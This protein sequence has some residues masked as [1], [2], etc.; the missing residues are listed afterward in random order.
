MVSFRRALYMSLGITAW[1]LYQV[2]CEGIEL[3]VFA[4]SRMWQITL[5]GLILFIV[6][7][8]LLLVSTWS[9]YRPHIEGLF[10]KF[11]RILKR[12]R[13]LSIFLLPIP[14]LAFPVLITGFYSERLESLALRLFLLWFLALAST[15]LLR[16]ISSR[17]IWGEA[18][19]ISSLLITLSYRIAL[20]LPDI[21][22][23]PFSLGY[24][25]ANRYY[26]ASLWFAKRIFGQGL[27]LSPWHPSR[28]ML[29]AIPFLIS[30]TPIWVHRLWQVGLWLLLPAITA[31]L[32]S[33][34]LK[35][36]NRAS[37]WITSGW[38]FFFLF[39][40][41]VY[42][43]LLLSVIPVLWWFEGK[44]FRR[45]LIVIILASIWAG[46]SRINWIPV[47]AFL[48]AILYVL[49]EIPE[50]GWDGLWRY[51]WKPA[52]WGIA[53]GAFALGAHYFYAFAS[54]N[55]LSMVQSS[56]T[57]D[58]L[59]YRLLP[60]ATYP[61]GIVRGVLLASAPIFF[62]IILHLIFRQGPR[63]A[64]RWLGYFG[65]FIVLFGGGLVVSSKIGGGGNL[66]NMDAYL[67]LLAVV[68]GYICFE[69]IAG[70][71]G[72]RR[73]ELRGMWIIFVILLVVPIAFTIEQDVR[74]V[75]Y[76]FQKAEENLALISEIVGGV[77]Q[78][79]GEVLFI[80][81]R[82]L[83]VFNYLENVPLS[84]DYEKV[85]LVEAA[86]S[87]ND[88]YLERFRQNLADHRYQLILTPGLS[89]QLQTREDAYGE[90]NNAWVEIVSLPI[91]EHYRLVYSI[92]PTGLWILEP[93][94]AG[95]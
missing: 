81:A 54:G 34:R 68:G 14:I 39:Q 16:S 4:S 84:R 80:D 78:N 1:A 32:F 88:R 62:L 6:L 61:L 41:P 26:Y 69:W 64:I 74:K 2:V 3:G 55:D 11:S 45:S 20:F 63:H 82:H 22:T 10:E 43:H 47:P 24:S 75:D 91:L 85:A 57:S 7:E 53:G 58:L 42:Y 33:R 73:R 28:Y 19:A 87:G 15:I 67:V 76:D 95:P 86:I 17:V 13:I 89:R 8:C 30:N 60:S 25:E 49:E 27:P 77:V 70:V 37:L 12:C 38:F 35:I 46:L 59:W 83:I 50:K 29:Q 5:S 23:Y 71:S 79:G 72:V 66:H 48:A 52:L 36:E 40:G 51:V 90:E 92:E 21:T 31:W 94:P 65:I 56:F 9:K 44:R 18:L 93:I